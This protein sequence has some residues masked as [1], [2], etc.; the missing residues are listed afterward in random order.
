MT[1]KKLAALEQGMTSIERKVYDAVPLVEWWRSNTIHQEL[2]RRGTNID[3]TVLGGCLRS[4]QDS[5]A[6]QCRNNHYKRVP[7]KLNE[8]DP[9]VL[10]APQ[11]SIVPPPET[12][13]P[14]TPY[15][16]LT[17]LAIEARQF[18]D[19]LDLAALEVQQQ[20]DQ[21]REDLKQLDQLRAILGGVLKK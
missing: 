5:K 16:I 15:D 4:L 17:E 10:V 3:P 1:P 7:V 2:I 19:K 20:F 9:D 11:L 18:A 21:S 13:M 14:R 6:V 12:P 8:P